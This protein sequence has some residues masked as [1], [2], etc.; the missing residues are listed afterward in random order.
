VDTIDVST[1][2]NTIQLGMKSIANSIVRRS[3]KLLGAFDG[4]LSERAARE[5][6]LRRLKKWMKGIV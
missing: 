1:G 2:E 4:K 5:L 6:E 3:R